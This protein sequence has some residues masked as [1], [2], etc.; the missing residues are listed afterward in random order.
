[1]EIMDKLRQG[2]CAINVVIEE[3][4]IPADEGL[5][6]SG[7][8]DSYSFVEFI[9]YIESE[10]NIEMGDDEFTTDNFRDLTAIKAYI[11]RKTNNMTLQ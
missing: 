8:L 9:G 11:E 1:M 10:F 4:N 7:I 6:A 5:V 2:V 3:A